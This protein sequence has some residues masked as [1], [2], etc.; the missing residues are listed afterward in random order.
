MSQILNAIKGLNPPQAR[1]DRNPI[2]N[3]APFQPNFTRQNRLQNFSYN[4]TWKDGQPIISPVKNENIKATPN[5]FSRNTVNMV[6]DPQD[7]NEPTWRIACQLPH[8]PEYCVVAF[9]CFG[10][11][12]P[13]VYC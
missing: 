6:D 4:I 7:A 5:P 12:E 9:S 2:E 10:N 3:K 8:A 11:E 13:H 1:I